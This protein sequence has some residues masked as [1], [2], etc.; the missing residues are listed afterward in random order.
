MDIADKS[1]SAIIR[2]GKVPVWRVVARAGCPFVTEMCKQAKRSGTFGADIELVESDSARCCGA[3][4]HAEESGR[5]LARQFWQLQY[6]F[7]R[8]KCEALVFEYDR[9]C[10]RF[11]ARRLEELELRRKLNSK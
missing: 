3:I 1:A 7:E 6:F 10:R 5:I 11:F 9:W 2:P 8:D 4:F